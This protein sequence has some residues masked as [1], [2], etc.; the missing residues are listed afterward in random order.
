M[1]RTKPH[2]SVSPDHLRSPQLGSSGQKSGQKFSPDQKTLNPP[3]RDPTSGC[4]TKR[5]TAGLQR[6]PALSTERV[7]LCS[8]LTCSDNRAHP[9]EDL[10]AAPRTAGPARF[11]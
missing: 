7:Y 2:P 3:E 6:V 11:E 9:L 4:A 8:A 1:R 10:A 5:L